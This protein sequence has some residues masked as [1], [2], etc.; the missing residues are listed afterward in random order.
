MLAFTYLNFIIQIVLVFLS[1][2]VSSLC[3]VHFIFIYLYMIYT[4][5]DYDFVWTFQENRDKLFQL[6]MFKQEPQVL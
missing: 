6:F 1:S 2:I 4:M 5:I 3:F